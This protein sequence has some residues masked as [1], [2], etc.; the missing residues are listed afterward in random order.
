LEVVV[1]SLSGYL[2]EATGQAHPVILI[3][4]WFFV[5]SSFYPILGVQHKSFG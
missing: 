2:Y 3:L 4:I 1:E 5:Q